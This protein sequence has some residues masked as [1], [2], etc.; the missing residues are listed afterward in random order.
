M[1]I[2]FVTIGEPIPHKDNKLRL[3]RT[4]ILTK[5]ISENS[6]SKVI[7]W[8]SN[9]NHFTKEHIYE[10][11]TDFVVNK[12]LSLIALSGKGYKRNVSIDRIIDHKQIANSFRKRIAISAKP[13]III[14]AFPTL[15]LCEICTDFGKNNNIPVIIDYRDMWPE[16]FVDIAPSAFKP[17]VQLLLSPLFNKTKNVFNSATGL[18]GIT[19]EFLKLGLRKAGRNKNKYDAVFP[20][21]YLRNQY[22]QKDIDKANLFWKEILV[23]EPQILRIC[24]FGTLGHQFDFDTVVAAVELLN[25]ENINDFE[26]VLCGSGDRELQL[27]ESAAKFKG[28]ILPGYM[29]AAQIRA[30][31]ELSD[32]GLCPYNVNQA[33][34]SSIPGKAIEYMSA[35]LPL[36]STLENGELG[37]L[38]HE[39]KIG[40]HYEFGN[41]ISLAN[42]IKELINIKSKLK[43]LHQSIFDLYLKN[44]EAKNIYSD[45][46]DHINKVVKVYNG[47]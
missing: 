3:H 45:Y 5:F 23:I 26:I 33:F 14:V 39:N 2:W 29:D 32:I 11:E 30:L 7:W 27:K 28:L 44:F 47:R 12:N 10:G 25:K 18:I 46:F 9:F 43:E 38:L 21:A 16:V 31:L 22:N 17:L 20:L 19:N 35:G 24:F 37:K 41:P 40:F 4:G 13:E 34:L 1:N 8:T 42:K 15:E 6:N 36:L